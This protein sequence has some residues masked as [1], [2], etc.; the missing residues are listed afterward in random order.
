MG[1]AAGIFSGTCLAKIVGGGKGKCDIYEGS[2]VVDDSYPM[3]N[4][5]LCPHIR[6]E[7]DCQKYGRPDK[8]YLKYRWQPKGCHLPRCNSLFLMIIPFHFFS[9]QFLLSSAKKMQII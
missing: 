7:F 9:F 4:S 2:W 1:V 3:Y 8:L 6:K 5:T